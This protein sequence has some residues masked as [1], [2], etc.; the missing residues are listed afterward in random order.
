MVVSSRF[1]AGGIPTARD[2]ATNATLEHDPE[3]LVPQLLRERQAF[4]RRSC[5]TAGDQHP[6]SSPGGIAAWQ[7]LME[8]AE[9]NRSRCERF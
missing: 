3:K 1:L 5:R 6:G 4:Q 9:R 7:A 2:H 8:V